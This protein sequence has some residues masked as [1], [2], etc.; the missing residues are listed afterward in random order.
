M[1][2]RCDPGPAEDEFRAKEDEF[3]SKSGGIGLFSPFDGELGPAE[4]G[5]SFFVPMP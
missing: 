5:R 4:G 3:H 1:E 2:P